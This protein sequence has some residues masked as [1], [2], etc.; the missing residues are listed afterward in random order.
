MPHQ[1]TVGKIVGFAFELD[2][3][4]LRRKRVIVRIHR[5]KVCPNR[6][7]DIAGTLSRTGKFH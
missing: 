5:V 2:G 7:R 3:D 1:C 4:N 6:T